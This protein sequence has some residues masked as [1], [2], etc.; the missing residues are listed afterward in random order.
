MNHIKK[1]LFI[2]I[3]FVL[4]FSSV[5]ADDTVPPPE[6]PLNISASVDVPASCDVIDVNGIS[7]HYA[8]S[9]VAICALQATI[10]QGNISSINLVT[11]PGVE[12]LFVNLINNVGDP[13]SQYWALY[14][15]RNFATLGLSL[16]PVSTNDVIELKLH[17][18]SN[19]DIGDS[20]SI[21]INSLIQEPT[22]EPEPEPEPEHHSSCGSYITPK[23]KLKLT[24]DSQKALDFLI[25]QQKENGSFGKDLYT[26]WATLALASNPATPRLNLDKIIKYFL[27]NK[28]SGTLV[29]DYERHAMALMALGLNPYNTNNENYIKK[30][31]AD[32][33]GTQFGDTNTDN[34]D[35]FALI[36]LQNAG[37]TQTDKI[38]KDDID[39]VLNKQNTDGS[40]DENVDL[41]SAGI[42]AL[43]F[44]QSEQSLEKN[45][46]KAKSYL[47]QNQ[48]ED[49]S[50]T[51][52]SSTS[53]AMQGILA[54]G[55]K[56]ENWIAINNTPLDYLSSNQDTDG[57]IKNENINNKIWETSYVL[58]SLSGKTW[59]QIM[60]KFDK[61]VLVTDTNKTTYIKTVKNNNK[62]KNKLKTQNSSI[63]KKINKFTEI[64]KITS[65]NTANVLKSDNNNQIKETEKAPQKQ[66]FFRKI[67]EIMF[68]I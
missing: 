27:E 13:T 38:I 25:S 56:I 37:F 51:N 34:D 68:G 54:M 22:P 63:A 52:V 66:N 58:T 3:V 45:L 47:K 36:V 18:F 65:Q 26:D 35:I 11:Y 33:D 49:G 43:S 29:T 44:F 2:L 42:E 48:K 67:L 17:D 8:N 32:F 28:F 55:E 14:Q 7:H 10:D 20:V 31:T 5:F 23:P 24:F 39:F 30:I 12:G 4:S 16:L 6:P 59:N 40:W 60:Q 61:P 21:T 64:A 9:Y 50:W 41:T 46:E 62:T 15:N 1:F 53:W 57:G 19:N